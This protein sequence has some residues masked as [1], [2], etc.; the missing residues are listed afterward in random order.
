MDVLSDATHD[1]FTKLV[2]FPMF[3]RLATGEFNGNEAGSNR[4]LKH[5]LFQR[6]RTK[7][8]CTMNREGIDEL[9]RCQN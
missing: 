7:A 3:Y 4:E 9:S 8:Q 2:A 6:C 5:D 1:T